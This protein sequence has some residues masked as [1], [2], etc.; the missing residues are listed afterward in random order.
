M[1]KEIY[2]NNRNKLKMAVRLNI[3]KQR[4]KLVFLEHGLG[5]RNDYPHM[6]VLEEIFA[7]N[8]YN[9]VNLD[10]CDSNNKSDKSKEGITF[11]GHYHDLEDVIEWA[12]TQSFYKEPFALSGQSLGAQAV[13]L[14]ASDYPEIVDLLMPV[15]FCWISGKEE[16]KNNSRRKIIEEQGF[17]EQFSKSTGKSFLIKMNYLD[18][19]KEYNMQKNICN[20][21][22]DTYIL[23][24]SLDKQS[25]IENSQK[26][27]DML[28][29]KKEFTMLE[30]V[31]HD[32][33]N[34]PE[35]KKT[36]ENALNEIFKKIIIV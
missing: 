13:V 4:D 16:S 25:H 24:G 17:F 21:K 36:F 23:V 28:K 30:N 1:V 34:T 31:P 22:A 18:D 12:K 8:G 33:A 14:Y 19:L 2:I 20:I 10:A 6:L 9:V 35:N 29:C 15:A 11:T 27:Y 7:K 26:L 3:D 5:A 32:L